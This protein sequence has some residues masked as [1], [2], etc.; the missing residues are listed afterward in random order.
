VVEVLPTVGPIE[1]PPVAVVASPT[2]P[3]RDV[4]P[5]TGIAAGVYVAM[6]MMLGLPLALLVVGVRA[7]SRRHKSD[8]FKL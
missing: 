8:V 4:L 5:A 7:R 1:T 6:L 2:P 3:T